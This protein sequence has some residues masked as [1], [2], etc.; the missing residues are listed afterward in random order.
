MNNDDSLFVRS[1]SID[2]TF[3]IEEVS[4]LTK[5]L[6]LIYDEDIGNDAKFYEYLQVRQIRENP[7]SANVII[8]MGCDNF[9][10][11]CIVPYTRGREVSRPKDE[12]IAEVR[13]HVLAGSREVTLLGQ[14]VNSYGKETRKKL[15]NEAE[16]KW[17]SSGS[18]GK[19]FRIGIDI[20]DTLVFTF[21]QRIFDEYNQKYGKNIQL[22]DIFN[23]AFNDDLHLREIYMK[24]FYAHHRSLP[25]FDGVVQ[26]IRKLKEA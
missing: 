14:N 12:I 9:C 25:L 4:Y 16:M 7:T 18:S 24:N 1:P 22:P 5:L 3:R 13:E 6:S 26:N 11:F 19:K 17:L 23:H 2:F 21:E 8:Q 10:S 20:D 15:W